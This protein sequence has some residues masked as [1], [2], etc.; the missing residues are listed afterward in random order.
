MTDQTEPTL[1]ELELR[2]QL[3]DAMD[4]NLRMSRRR[5]LLNAYRDEILANASSAGRAPAADRA[6]DEQPA[7]FEFRGTAEIRAAALLEAASLLDQRATGIDAFASSDYGEE[8]RA[9]RELAD[10]ANALRRLAGEAQQDPGICELPHLTIEEEDACEAQQEPRPRCP[11]CQLPHDLTPGSMPVAACASILASIANA[12]QLHA[13]GDHSRCAAVDCEVVRG[14]REAQQ[15]P[16]QDGE[17]RETDEQRADREETE[18]DHAAGDHTYCGITCETEL[19]TEHLRNFVIA[20]GY[21]GTKGALDE[22]LRRAAVAQPGQPE[23]A[24]ETPHT[25]A[26]S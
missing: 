7:E 19:P 3:S 20:K 16:T 1:A 23:T 8:A 22:L 21:P 5:E 26:A 11:H 6:A 24:S 13:E 18:R 10:A 17:E 15:D 9:V 2:E 4:G 14:C 25:G 12:D